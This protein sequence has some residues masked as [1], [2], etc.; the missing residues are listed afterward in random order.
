MSNTE[1][2]FA[3]IDSDSTSDYIPQP[4]KQKAITKAILKKSANSKAPS[5]PRKGAIPRTDSVT[6]NEVERVESDA[7]LKA[8]KAPEGGGKK[9]NVEEIYQK[10]MQ[11][12]HIL[13]RPDTYIG[14]TKLNSQWQWIYNDTTDSLI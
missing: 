13:L 14:S 3:S 9:K 7:D 12:E 2:S 8:P 10:K 4:K 6:T 5:K 1:A 11:L